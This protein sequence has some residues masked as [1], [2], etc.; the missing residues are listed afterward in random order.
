MNNKIKEQRNGEVKIAIK[1]QQ[2]TQRFLIFAR[3]N[4]STMKTA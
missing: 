2:K 4:T 1:N 3:N